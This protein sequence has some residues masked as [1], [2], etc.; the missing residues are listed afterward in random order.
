MSKLKHIIKLVLKCV[1]FNN[2]RNL[3][4]GNNSGIGAFSKVLFSN[5]GNKGNQS[6]IIGNYSGVGRFCE[7]HVWENNHI[8]IKDYATLNDGCKILG[9]VTIERH[10]LFSSN[11]F[12]SSGNHYAMMNPTWLI[13]DQD[14]EAW[15]L[16]KAN[17]L[18]LPIHVEEDCW[19]GYGVFLKQ[20]IYIGRGA[21]IGANSV[22]MKDVEPYSIQAGSPCKEIKKRID[23]NPPQKLISNN[24]D[25]L[26]YFYRGFKQRREDLLIS[27][28]QN[29]VLSLSESMAVLKK[30]E[31]WQ[32]ISIKG[33]IANNSNTVEILVCLNNSYEW[34]VTAKE[35]NFTFELNKAN[36]KLIEE[37]NSGTNNKTTNNVLSQ[38]HVI[39]FK[40]KSSHSDAVFGVEEIEILKS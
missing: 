20:G 37:K 26:P 13:K 2:A 19:V 29:A 4:I 12:A 11:I 23:F 18:S 31:D 39:V 40:T 25:H 33:I 28:K 32:K 34:E 17:E 3:S 21:I 7:L 14:K 16:Q 22:V 38:Y 24:D 15:R 6:I 35:K 9:D 10:C 5:D 1:Y 8:Q 27:R 36:A 30:Q